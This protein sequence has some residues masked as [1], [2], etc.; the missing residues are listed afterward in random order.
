[1]A[2]HQEVQQQTALKGTIAGWV[3]VHSPHV[4]LSDLLAALARRRVWDLIQYRYLENRPRWRRYPVTGYLLKPFN[5]L[6]LLSLFSARKV[7]S[8]RLGYSACVPCGHQ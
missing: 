3:G 7:N 8:G 5:I 6:R 1:M 2:H 4:N